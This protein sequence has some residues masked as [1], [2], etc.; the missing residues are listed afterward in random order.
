MLLRG[1][2]ICGGLLRRTRRLWPGILSRADPLQPMQLLATD[3]LLARE[4]FDRWED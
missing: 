2:E 4:F 1:R 3:R